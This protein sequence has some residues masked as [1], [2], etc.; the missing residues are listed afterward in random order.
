[1]LLAVPSSFALA[2]PSFETGPYLGSVTTK[3]RPVVEFTA[4]KKKVKEVDIESQR[5]ECSD[6][7]SG[8]IN[9]P[10]RVG[11]RALKLKR[12]RFELRI[13]ADGPDPQNAGTRVTGKLKGEK[14][15]GT[16]RIVLHLG[17]EADPVICDTGRRKWKAKL[18]E[19]I[20][21]LP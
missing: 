5:V 12:G 10:S 4:T 15:T 19:V 1:V 6:G 9:L 18:D 8:T 2:A 14:A 16:V 17:T 21:E 13:T 20:V 11:K 3:G 7:R